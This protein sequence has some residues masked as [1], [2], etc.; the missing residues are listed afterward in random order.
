MDKVTHRRTTSINNQ[1]DPSS[2]SLSSKKRE[3]EIQGGGGG[4]EE[5]DRPPTLLLLL[6]SLEII[7]PFST[8][9]DRPQGHSR[10]NDS[11]RPRNRATTHPIPL[12]LPSRSPHPSS[13]HTSSGGGALHYFSA[14]IPL[15]PATSRRIEG[16]FRGWQPRAPRAVARVFPQLPARDAM[17]SAENRA[18]ER[19]KFDTLF[20]IVRHCSAICQVVRR[21]WESV[22]CV[23]AGVR[24]GSSERRVKDL[25]RLVLYASSRGRSEFF[26]VFFRGKWGS[27][28]GEEAEEEEE[29][30]GEKEEEERQS[31]GSVSRVFKDTGWWSSSSVLH[32]HCSTRQ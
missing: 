4:E 10:I 27:L 7:S 2:I 32:D 19:G 12:F 26:F 28:R 25:L 15:W 6:D 22:G 23:A 5:K 13:V 8:R 3:H 17:P 30:E 9:G 29:E 20:D 21:W 24:R 14:W 18:S 11:H 31:R 1:L 16:V